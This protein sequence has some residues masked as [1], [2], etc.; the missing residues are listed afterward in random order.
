MSQ[1][2]NKMNEKK[3]PTSSIPEETPAPKNSFFSWKKLALILSPGCIYF[4]GYCSLAY[5]LE[6]IGFSSPKIPFDVGSTYLH[7]FH[8]LL[9]TTDLAVT[10][11]KTTYFKQIND[12]WLATS[13]IS[14][15]TSVVIL[16]VGWGVI[17]TR[18][19]SSKDSTSKKPQT[20][21]PSPQLTMKKVLILSG[22]GIFSI[23]FLTFLM[24][25]L[26]VAML[27]MPTIILI[28]PAALGSRM[29]ADEVKNFSC[30]PLENRRYL[31]CATIEFRD[32]SQIAGRIYL[33]NE[34]IIYVRTAETAMEIPESDVLKVFR[35]DLNVAKNSDLNIGPP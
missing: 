27:V 5:Y 24:L 10:D 3:D 30:R 9:F 17:Q 15:I 4:F 29:A 8:S 7:A 16:L 32:K 35:K 18:K 21:L 22:A 12:G 6:G 31:P 1:K 11:F 19:K 26:L 2:K 28:I 14:A 13:V 34:G 23:N 25:P 20:E 33:R